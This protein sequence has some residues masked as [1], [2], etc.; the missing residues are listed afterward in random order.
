MFFNG[1]H[2]VI[3]REIKSLGFHYEVEFMVVGDTTLGAASFGILLSAALLFQ[4]NHTDVRKHC[5]VA[6]DEWFS[7]NLFQALIRMVLFAAGTVFLAELVLGWAIMAIV[8]TVL[9]SR[10][11]IRARRSVNPLQPTASRPTSR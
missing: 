5:G 2:H 9:L 8:A 1:I 10:E 11:L 7:Q 3:P 6:C 4:I